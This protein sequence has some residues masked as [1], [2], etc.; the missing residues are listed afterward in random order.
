MNPSYTL[1]EAKQK[2]EHY[3]AYQDRCHKEVVQ[4]LRQMGMIP[5]AIDQL[6]GGLIAENYLNEM[7]FAQSFARGKFRIKH[8][9]KN[10]IKRELQ[11]RDISAYCIQAGLKEIDPQD[12]L[13][14]F[15]S[16]AEKKGASLNHLPLA[17]QR[18]KLADYLFYRGWESTLVYEKIQELPIESNSF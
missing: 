14:S 12:Y 3:C 10:R 8:W 13:A 11:L 1:A 9:G 5:A 15:H 4:K 18:K 2:I 6:M 7:R 16:L 17:Q